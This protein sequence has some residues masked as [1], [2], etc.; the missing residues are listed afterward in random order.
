MF[1]RD[2]T[3]QDQSGHGIGLTRIGMVRKVR[4]GDFPTRVFHWSLVRCLMDWVAAVELAGTVMA[5][6]FEPDYTAC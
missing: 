3:Q 2:R 4:I 1:R 6:H 5:W